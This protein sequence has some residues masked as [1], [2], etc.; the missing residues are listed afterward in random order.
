ML[1]FLCI[2]NVFIHPTALLPISLILSFRNWKIKF[3][4]QWTRM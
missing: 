4:L 3:V 1:I 2:F